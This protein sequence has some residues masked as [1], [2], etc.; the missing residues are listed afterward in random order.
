[1]RRL[2][3]TVVQPGDTIKVELPFRNDLPRRH[4][5]RYDFRAESRTERA[6]SSIKWKIVAAAPSLMRRRARFLGALAFSA[7][8]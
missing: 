7:G 1:L 5:G 6:G 4:L 2:K 3:A 8:R